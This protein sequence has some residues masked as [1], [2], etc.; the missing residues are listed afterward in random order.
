MIAIKGMKMPENCDECPARD[1]TYVKSCV[2]FNLRGEEDWTDNIER[3]SSCPLVEVEVAS[4]EPGWVTRMREEYKELQ[5]RWE[6][7]CD[8]Y[9]SVIFAG[10][11]TNDELFY[12]S[13]QSEAMCQYA[14]ALEKRAEMKG[15]TLEVKGEGEE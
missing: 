7:L 10:T 8:Y 1:G 9:S 2:F 12:L 6:K 15:Y 14:R 5:R 11:A 3:P 13:M 4:E